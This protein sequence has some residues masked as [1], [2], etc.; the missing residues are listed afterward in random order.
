MQ[1]FRSTKELIWN[2]LLRIPSSSHSKVQT[3]KVRTTKEY[4]HMRGMMRVDFRYIAFAL[5]SL[6]YIASFVN[7]IFRVASS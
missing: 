5:Y 6:T 1:R 4:H 2:K 7:C 3:S